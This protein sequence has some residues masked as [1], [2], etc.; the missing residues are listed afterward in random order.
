MHAVIHPSS[1]QQRVKQLQHSFHQFCKFYY[2]LG[3]ALAIRQCSNAVVPCVFE[4]MQKLLVASHFVTLTG[5][6]M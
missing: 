3:M 2:T 1:Q 4:A 5:M 6:F